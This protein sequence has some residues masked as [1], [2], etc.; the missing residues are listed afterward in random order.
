MSTPT[1]ADRRRAGFRLILETVRARRRHLL[2]ALSGASLYTAVVLATPLV[3][4]AVI[5]T[6]ITHHHP[7]RLRGYVMMLLALAVLRAA[8]GALRKY[9]ATKGPAHMSNDLRR[10]LYDHFQRLSFSFHDRMGAG[11]LMARASTDVTAVE[12]VLNPLP[13]G[14]QSCAMFVFGVLLLLFVQPLLASAV[15]VVVAIGIA[16][17]LRRA[18]SLYPASL[19]VQERLGEWSEFVEQQVQGIRVVKGHGFERQFQHDGADL[20]AN[21][22]DAGI[23]LS[24]ARATFQAALIAGPGCAFVVVVGLG[25]WLGAT[26]RISPGHLLAFLQYLAILVAPVTVG[27]EFLSQWPQAS[28]AAARI[29][30]VLAAEPDVAEPANARPLRPGGGAVRFEHVTFAY[31]AGRPV[32]ADLDLDIAAGSCVALVGAAGAGKTTAAFLTC[33]FYDPSSGVVLLDDQPVNEIHLADLRRAVSIVFE[34]TVVFTATIRENLRV[35]SPDASDHQIEHAAR[36]SEADEF[37][38]ALPYG[39]DTVVGPQGYSLSG[40][41]RQ[42]L[43]I[44]RAILRDARLL[45]LDDALSAVDPPTEAAIRRGLLE[46]M[47]G[48]TTL[49]IAHRIETISLADRVVLLDAGRVVAD[50][51]HEELLKI[52]AYRHALAIDERAVAP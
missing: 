31:A 44:A 15:A 7:G 41:Q 38:R 2:F 8:S 52:P 22:R 9:Q 35:G 33:R 51:T 24:V 6:V 46:A 5:D 12:Q 17:A 1:A 32:L 43:A 30:E 48:R 36:L 21:S 40:G 25:A 4:G 23:T 28:A 49:V 11:Q 19:H 20:A 47:K 42:R 45:I 10:R 37:I 18:T 14:I 27:A 16:C 13:W 34:D 39:Y 50:G 3:A 29:A 26:G